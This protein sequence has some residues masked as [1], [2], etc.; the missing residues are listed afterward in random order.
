MSEKTLKFDN[1]VNKKEF[2]KSKQPINIDQIVVVDKFKH[3]DDGFKCFIGYEEDETVKTLCIILPQMNSYIKYFENGGKN[4]SFIIK[5]D[6]VL[7]KYDKMWDKIK[8]KLNMKLHSMPAYD[9]K[10]MKAKVREFNGVIKTNFLGDKVPKENEHYTCITCITIESYPQVYL[11]EFKY[12]MKKTKMTNFI[13]AELKSESELE[14]DTELVLKSK[15]ESDTEYLSK[16]AFWA[17]SF[18]DNG[19][20]GNSKS[21]VLKYIFR[22]STFDVHPCSEMYFEFLIH[23]CF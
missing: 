14:S 22:W 21:H 20:E 12:G 1:R 17:S 6:D 4:M 18:K 9:E 11:E 3:N 5:N 15:S 19:F 7:D 2:H 8:G 16:Q 13:K 23:G 10:Y